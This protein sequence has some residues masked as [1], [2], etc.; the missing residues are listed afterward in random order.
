MNILLHTP[1]RNERFNLNK[2]RDKV[3]WFKISSRET[4]VNGPHE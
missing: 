3:V 1:N 2:N 4:G